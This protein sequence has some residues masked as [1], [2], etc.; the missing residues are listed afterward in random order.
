MIRY[1]I[2]SIIG[3]LVGYFVFYKLIGCSGGSCVITSNPYIS[4]IYGVVAGLLFSSIIALP[5]ESNDAI[6][7][8]QTQVQAKAA[9]KTITAK[10][11]KEKIDG[12]S[13]VIVLDVRTKEEYVIS[14]I[15]GAILIP[16]DTITDKKP[17]LLPNLDAEILIYCRSGRRSAIAAE[18]LIELGYTNVY[19]FGGIIDWN[20]ETATGTDY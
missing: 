14:H 7:T 18:A 17:D 13:E 16:Y 5:K 8:T 20:Y 4:T 11:A 15:G 6:S 3:G 2:G 1:L 10:E 12:D 19:D 9:Y